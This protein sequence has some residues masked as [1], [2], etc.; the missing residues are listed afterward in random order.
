MIDFHQDFGGFQCGYGIHL[1]CELCNPNDNKN[2]APRDSIL[3][4][5]LNNLK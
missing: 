3:L 1:G 5:A 2:E 4:S